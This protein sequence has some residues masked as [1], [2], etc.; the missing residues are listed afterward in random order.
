VK[1]NAED[2]P[3]FHQAMN[4]EDA[5][6]F[7]HAMEEEYDLLKSQFDA[8]EIVP[9]SVPEAHGK[10]IL[11]TTWAFKRKHYPDGHVKKLKAWLCIHGDQQMEGIDFFET[12]S[13]VIAWS[14]VRLL[15]VLSVVLELKLIQVD[16]TNAFVQAPINDEVYCEM[17][18]MVQQEGYVL[19]LK[20]NVYGLQQVNF[21]LLLKEALEQ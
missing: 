21:F 2:T 4:S 6:G 5:E 11:G 17:P 12:Y 1:A 9:C 16:Y 20:Q 3:N 14:T 15:M 19:Q 7:Y 13:P 18:C 10:N 8:W